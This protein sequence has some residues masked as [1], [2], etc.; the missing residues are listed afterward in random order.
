MMQRGGGGRAGA[1][2]QRRKGL[3]V[4]RR[5]AT[6]ARRA[7]RRPPRAYTL[8]IDRHSLGFALCALVVLQGS[9][10][11]HTR[12]ASKSPRP[13]SA[14]DCSAPLPLR[15]LCGLRALLLLLLH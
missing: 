2:T 13:V 8:P 7:G 11:R 1:G 3:A 6:R 10:P 12:A 15:C 14:G 5:G 9:G 4:W